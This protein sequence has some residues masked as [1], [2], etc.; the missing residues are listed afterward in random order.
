MIS[1]FSA[2][3]FLLFLE[4]HVLAITESY[5]FLA[6]APLWAAAVSWYFF[7]RISVMVLAFLLSASAASFFIIFSVSAFAAHA[8]AVF[9]SALFFIFMACVRARRMNIAALFFF[10][11]FLSGIFLFLVARLFFHFSPFIVFPGVFFFSSFLFFFSHTIALDLGFWVKAR[12]WCF[13]FVA[14][15]I[16]TELFWALNSLPLH[17]INIAF[18]LGIVY[19]SLWHIAHRYFSLR[20]TKRMLVFDVMACVAGIVTVLATAK[21]LPNS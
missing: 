14:G 8:I 4:A 2:L 15:L 9:F 21:W 10:P 5:I 7:R 19:Y 11:I 20:F 1:F 6:L 13:S 18:L 3:G 17:V 12:L 16:M